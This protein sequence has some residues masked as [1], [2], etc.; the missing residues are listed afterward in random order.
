M[1]TGMTTDRY[2]S[3]DTPGLL[4]MSKAPRN[5]R[6]NST[7]QELTVLGKCYGKM[8]TIMLADILGRSV[9]SIAKAKERLRKH[10]AIKI[11]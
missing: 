8:D 5:H 7:V 9:I 2:T 3:F 10:R 4:Q 1:F 11:K 6:C